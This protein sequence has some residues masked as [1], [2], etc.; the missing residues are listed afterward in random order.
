MGLGL[1]LL[2][3]ALAELDWVTGVGSHGGAASCVLEP[4][5]PPHTDLVHFD[6]SFIMSAMRV[7]CK[8][9]HTQEVRFLFSRCVSCCCM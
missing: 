8:D 4:F 1:G 9:G 5:A 2:S 3:R 7:S 6:R